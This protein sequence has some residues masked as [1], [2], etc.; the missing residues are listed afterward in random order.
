MTDDERFEAIGSEIRKLRTRV[1][2]LEHKSGIEVASPGV[3]PTG[4]EPSGTKDHEQTIADL[5]RE[6]EGARRVTENQRRIANER[7]SERD[8]AFYEID[9]LKLQLEELRAESASESR[10]ESAGHLDRGDDEGG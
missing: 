2:A 5:R 6:L 1:M 3:P 10:T 8:A 9:R 7:T 4:S